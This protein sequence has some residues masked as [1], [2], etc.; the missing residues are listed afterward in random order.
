MVRE[1]I[2]MQMEIDMK[3]NGKIIKEMVKESNIIRMVIFILVI[4][5]KIINK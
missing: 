1:L 4:G 2:Y 3:G 5:I